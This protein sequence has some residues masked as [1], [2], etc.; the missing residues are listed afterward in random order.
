MFTRNMTSSSGNKILQ[1]NFLRNLTYDEIY[2]FE[3][4]TE[5]FL[6]NNV[7][8]IETG[9]FTGRSPKDKYIV[10]DT[11]TE[12]QIWWGNVNAPMS[13]DLFS[14]LFIA[15]TDHYQR[16]NEK[17]FIF[18]GYCGASKSNSKKIRFFT[19]NIWQ[20]HFLK[21]MFI[22]TTENFSTFEPDFTIINAST[23][24]FPEWESHSM[25][26][27]NFIAL[28]IQ[29]KVGLI[30]GTKYTGEMKKSVFSLMNY[31]LPSSNVLPMHCSANINHLG[32][33]T[34][35]FGLSGTGK[36]T[37]STDGDTFLIG[38]DE[39]GWDENGIFNFE[40]GCYAKT[41]DLDF[42]KEPILYNAI[43]KNALVENVK[44][45][46]STMEPDFC[47]TEITEN[48]RVSFPI[49]HIPNYVKGSNGGHPKNII[50]LTCDR[51]GVLPFVSKLDRNQV[52]KYF[53]L[54]YTSKV[55]GTERGIINPEITFSPCFGGAFLTLPPKVYGK[56]LMEKIEN[57]DCNVFL[58]NTGWHGGGERY[59]IEETRK[60]IRQIMNG[61]ILSHCF[62]RDNL[63]QLNF[64]SHLHPKL[65][66]RKETDYH[67]AARYLK[68]K[69]DEQSEILGL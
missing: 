58:V 38:D 25:N 67:K 43:R 24:T 14:K 50:F 55:A 8:V 66:W 3:K 19:E 61:D 32:E 41:K 30:G 36:T 60:I 16:M 45:N 12:S 28:D 56:L 21:N 10:N 64:P 62:I 26:S 22:N 7:C 52:Y 29:R 11:I 63:F 65:F 39:H 4:T 18:D 15:C 35:F 37:L 23:Y 17:F 42:R 57:H 49:D 6:N 54:G 20:H 59:S 9:S 2:Q 31:W 5:K 48:G 53:L 69:F 27:K 33:S 40:G 13:P 68:E 51:F 46:L 1:K 47:N 44:V 34:L